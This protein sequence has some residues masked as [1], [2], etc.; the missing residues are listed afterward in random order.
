MKTKFTLKIKGAILEGNNQ[1]KIDEIEL[2]WINEI[3]RE[4]LLER[5][6]E[7]LNN[8]LF[9]QNHFHGLKSFDRAF[10]TAEPSDD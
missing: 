2:V 7:Y 10:L 1:Q 9:L 4:E 5:S 3:S 6:K 8:K